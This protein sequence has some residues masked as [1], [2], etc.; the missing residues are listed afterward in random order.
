MRVHRKIQCP[1]HYMLIP[2]KR[3]FVMERKPSLK[4]IKEADAKKLGID[5]WQ[6]KKDKFGRKIQDFKNYINPWVSAA[7]MKMRLWSPTN[8]ICNAC[9]RCVTA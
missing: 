9:K 2:G 4:N 7:E 8:H 6:P 3:P 5:L 1:R